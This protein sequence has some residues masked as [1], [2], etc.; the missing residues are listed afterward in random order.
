MVEHFQNPPQKDPMKKYMAEQGYKT[1]GEELTNEKWSR[2]N[3][4]FIK[5]SSGL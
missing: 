4:M 3:F 2:E 5:I 1:Y